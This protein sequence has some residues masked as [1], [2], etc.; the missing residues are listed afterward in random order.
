MSVR[1]NLIAAKALLASEEN[2][3][4][5]YRGTGSAIVWAFDEVCP[6]DEGSVSDM[7]I[8]IGPFWLARGGHA[9]LMACLDSAIAAAGDDK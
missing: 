1:E 2:Y 5:A 4:K 7:F 8:A 3:L 6:D 9:G